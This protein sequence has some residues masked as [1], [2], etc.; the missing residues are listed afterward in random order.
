MQFPILLAGAK[1][2]AEDPPTLRV[3][4][5]LFG[6]LLAILPLA[7]VTAL[8]NSLTGLIALLALLQFRPASWK[9]IPGL[10]PWIV[11]LA[12]A[13][14][15]IAWS[16]LPDASFQSFRSDQ[17]Y[18]FIIFMVSFLVVRYL[19]GRLAVASGT[20]AGTLLCLATMFAAAALAADPDAAAPE[21]GVMGWLAWKAGNTTDASTYVAFVAV[22]LFLI[23]L[24]SRHAWRRWSAAVWLLLFAA[25]GFLSESRTLV[26]TLFV[27]FVGFLFALGILR[28]RLHWKS[29]LVVVAIGVAVSAACLEIISRVRMASPPSSSRSAAVELIMADPRPAMWAVYLELARKH[30]WLGIGLGRT[31]PS[32]V[33]RLHED[34]DLRR[35]DVQAATHAHNVV[36]DLVLQ[37][38]LIGLSLWLW[39]HVEILR[40]GWQRARGAGDREKAWAAAAVAL[41]LAMLV[42]NSTNDLIV[43]GNAILFW[44]LM[45]TMLGLIWCGA[46]PREAPLPAA[47]V[48]GAGQPA[49]MDAS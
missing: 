42:K 26:A 38:G 15:S 41:A 30:P 37:V 35:I 36:L 25:I 8:R 20:A 6:V 2:I 11:W 18:P 7:H 45:G 34:A 48:H 49:E 1:S 23:L 46:R 4:C 14:G 39:L 21:P 27:S 5:L 29:V 31:V 28:G 32:R 44:A 43:Y 3:L 19:G 9:N 40:L 47:A 13:A 10:M 33:Y 24:T 16:A 17:F 22:P 12:F